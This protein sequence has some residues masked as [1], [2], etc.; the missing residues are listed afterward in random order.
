MTNPYDPQ[1]ANPGDPY[2]GQPAP[3]QPAPGQ[4]VPGQ[5]YPGQPYPGQP[6]A[7]GPA[8]GPEPD[9]NLVWAIL[10]TILCC[11]PL[12]IVAIIKSTSV[13]KLW[14]QGDVV[15]AQKAADDAKKFAMWGAIAAV[16]LWVLYIIFFVVVGI[17]GSAS[18]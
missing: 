17:A 1:G 7:A 16:V 3:G 11:L 12:G 14:A 10:S 15:G 5:P 8:M 18:S 4:P 6:Y 2:Q 13:G 9:N